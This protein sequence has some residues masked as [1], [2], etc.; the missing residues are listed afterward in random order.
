MDQPLVIEAPLMWIDKA[1]TW[2]MASELGGSALVNLIRTETHTCYVGDHST[3]HDWGYGCGACP[4]C[5]LR[6]KGYVV[7]ASK[8]A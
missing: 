5:E 2:K 1:Q 8:A 3:L 6:Q 4:A 7:F